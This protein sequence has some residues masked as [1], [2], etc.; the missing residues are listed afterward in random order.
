[1]RH[2]HDS[3]HR[4]PPLH[5][6]FLVTWISSQQ[7]EVDGMAD[8]YTGRVSK[9]EWMPFPFKTPR[10]SSKDLE[11]FL[12]MGI[13]SAT[14]CTHVPPFGRSAG[15]QERRRNEPIFLVAYEGEGFKYSAWSKLFSP[16]IWPD[17]YSKITYS[18]EYFKSW[19]PFVYGFHGSRKHSKMKLINARIR[20]L[21]NCTWVN[22]NSKT[23][24]R[25]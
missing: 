6:W 16:K 8:K 11:A 1:M 17:L 2:S 9:Q 23:T 5:M 13:L 3:P 4:T 14:T 7:L 24:F 25:N 12:S 22:P 15:F 21:Y 19:M 18:A 20:F 10:S